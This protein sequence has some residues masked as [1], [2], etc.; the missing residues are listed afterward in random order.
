MDIGAAGRASDAGV[1]GQSTL[2]KTIASNSL[3]LPGPTLLQEIPGFRIHYH[4][5]GDDAFPMS[6]NLMKPYPQRNLEVET[7]IFNYRLSRARRVVEN[8]FGILAHRWRV[9]LTTIEMCP[10]KLTYVIFAACCLHNYL[11][12][13]NKPTYASA[14]DLENADH[15]ISNGAWR[16][17]ARLC[18]LQ[19]SLNHNPPRN[20]K[21]QRE[22]LTTYFNSTGSVPWQ[23]NMIL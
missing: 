10:D 8:A 4:I 11:V 15:T 5:V 17:D 20:A 23:G 14:V 2:K 9:F 22:M 21:E 1:Y 3:D 16:N 6:E 18:G 19:S 7:R 12:E 13:R